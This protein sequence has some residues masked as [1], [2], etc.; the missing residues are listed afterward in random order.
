MTAC[1]RR[2]RSEHR[3]TEAAGPEMVADRSQI[4]LARRDLSQA[5]LLFEALVE[6]RHGDEL[7]DAWEEAWE[8]GDAWK[9][10]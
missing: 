3:V 6:T 8:R 9:E 4:T 1:G 5:A 2:N 10:T 7:A